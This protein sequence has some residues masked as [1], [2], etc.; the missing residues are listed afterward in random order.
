M[1]LAYN[2]ENVSIVNAVQTL[3]A[4]DWAIR[5]CPSVEATVWTNF[6]GILDVVTYLLGPLGPL[7]PLVRVAESVEERHSAAPEAR[8]KYV[9]SPQWFS[10]KDV[11]ELFYIKSIEV[12]R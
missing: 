10:I 11:L 7:S 6:R 2:W 1:C 3:V 12:K 4:V 5:H 9:T 8:L